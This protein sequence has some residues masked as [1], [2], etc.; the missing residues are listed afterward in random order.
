[1]KQMDG[2]NVARNTYHTFST[3]NIITAKE[4]KIVT[5]ILIVTERFDVLLTVLNLRIILAI[6]QFHAQILVL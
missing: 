1:M 5:T 3:K 6:D 2:I 4:P